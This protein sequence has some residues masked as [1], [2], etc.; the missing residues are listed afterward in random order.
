[1]DLIH[2][3]LSLIGELNKSGVQYALCG[4]L[5]LGIKDS[6]VRRRTMKSIAGRLQD[7]ADI[8]RL[9]ADQGEGDADNASET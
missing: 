7:L 3:M 5:A 9:R 4:G 8:E 6:L 1:M 2:E